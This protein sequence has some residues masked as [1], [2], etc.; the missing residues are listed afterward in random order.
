MKCPK[1]RWCLKG[2]E[3]TYK[4]LVF[5]TDSNVAR[6]ERKTVRLGKT[7]FEEGWTEVDIDRYL[8]VD[9]PKFRINIQKHFTQ[10]AV[11]YLATQEEHLKADDDDSVV[12]DIEEMIKKKQIMRRGK[13]RVNQIGKRPGIRCPRWRG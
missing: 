6:A 4:P 3:E 11:R 9:K 8:T 10:D 2:K 12:V 7:A 13:L 5:T 1:S